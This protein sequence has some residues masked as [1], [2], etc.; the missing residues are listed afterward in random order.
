MY[1]APTDASSIVSK[2]AA[3][4]LA[5]ER[6]GRVVALHRPTPTAFYVNVATNT[7]YHSFAGWKDVLRLP[8]PELVAALSDA[9]VR[10]RLREGAEMSDRPWANFADTTIHEVSAPVLGP[11][12]GRRLGQLV[13][14][15]VDV[16]D[17]AQEEAPRVRAVDGH[18]EVGPRDGDGVL[19]SPARHGTS[20]FFIA[21]LEK[22]SQ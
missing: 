17:G 2:L 15:L 20:G 8:R 21:V 6:G 12:R 13:A 11:L 22:R 5:R 1:G 4:D 18:R 19:L 14:D 16:R 3:S 10:R 9:A 7:I